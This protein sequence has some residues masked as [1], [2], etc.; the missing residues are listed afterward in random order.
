[1]LQQADTPYPRSR[2]ATPLRPHHDKPTTTA[3][4]SFADWQAAT[5][6]ESKL[7]FAAVYAL[8]L[9]FLLATLGLL[10]AAVVE[11]LASEVWRHVL[12]EHFAAVIGLP[13]AAMTALFLVLGLHQTMGRMEIDLPGLKLRGAAAG[14]LLWTGSFVAMGLVLA[15]VW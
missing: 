10:V 8:L 14:I 1:M 4:I 11:L 15:R 7:R 2:E 13:A 6:F 5:P 12:R 3:P 9:L